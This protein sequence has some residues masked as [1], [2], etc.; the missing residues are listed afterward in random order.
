M[1]STIFILVSCLALGACRSNPPAAKPTP[2]VTSA[3]VAGEYRTG[4]DCAHGTP[5]NPTCTSKLELAPDGKGSF[6]GDDIVEA[7]TWQQTGDKI[8]VVLS[9]RSM[10]LAAKPDGTLVDE[11][12]QVWSRKA[13]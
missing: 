1:R 8:T 13:E 12:G 5:E 10:E 9:G 2:T 4:G 6:I 11:H 7:A 3:G